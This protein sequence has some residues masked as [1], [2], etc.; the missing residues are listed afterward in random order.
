M[1]FVIVLTTMV[2]VVVLIEILRVLITFDFKYN[3][4]VVLPLL[5]GKGECYI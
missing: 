3:C 1:D 5:Y 4:L 2:V